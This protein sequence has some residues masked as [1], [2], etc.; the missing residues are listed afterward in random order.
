MPGQA[1]AIERQAKITQHKMQW[2]P[3]EIVN[4]K[5]MARDP[6]TFPGEADDL[7][8]LQMMKEKRAAY[9]VKTVIT[10]GKG[11]RIA[12][13]GRMHSAQMGWGAVQ[14]HGAYRGSRL[15]QRTLRLC[16]NVALSA[17]HVH[18]GKFF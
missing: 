16:S 18:P 5:R 12:A 13:D 15:G 17:G 4:K 6:Q 1:A 10:K 9:G 3:L 8:R 2:M 7:L 14:N 11:Q